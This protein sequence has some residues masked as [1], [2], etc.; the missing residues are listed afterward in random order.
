MVI[1]FESTKSDDFV[2]QVLSV[3]FGR[4]GLIKS[5]PGLN[6]GL[7]MQ[8]I[9]VMWWFP[10]LPFGMA[11][12]VYEEVRKGVIRYQPIGSWLERETCY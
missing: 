7:R 4:N 8:P 11:M 1:T 10:S 2:F 12:L 9:R 5:T 6:R 3:S